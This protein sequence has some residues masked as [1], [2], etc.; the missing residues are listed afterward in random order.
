MVND[1]DQT[2]TLT[3][4]EFG[5]RHTRPTL[6]LDKRV[7]D[8]TTYK[9]YTI[10]AIGNGKHSIGF[11]KKQVKLTSNIERIND[12]AIIG[13]DCDLEFYMCDSP[14]LKYI[15]DN[16][17]YTIDTL[18]VHPGLTIGS[19][20]AVLDYLEFKDGTPVA[21]HSDKPMFQRIGFIN[22]LD[23]T[24]PT[25]NFPL[26]ASAKQFE[27]IITVPDNAKQAYL[28]NSYWKQ[29]RNLRTVSEHKKI[30]AEEAARRIEVTTADGY[31]TAKFRI[32]DDN[33]TVT[34]LNITSSKNSYPE[35][36]LSKPVI[37]PRT[38]KS[39]SITEIGD[40]EN[41]AGY[42]GA[43][44]ITPNIKRIN[45]YS[46]L[47]VKS[48]PEWNKV[49]YI[50]KYALH[51]E[52]V[53]EEIYI[54]PNTECVMNGSGYG[55][56]FRS[57]QFQYLRIGDGARLLA[58]GTAQFHVP[59]PIIRCDGTTPPELSAP[60][61]E[62]AA[63]YGSG[64]TILYVPREAIEA[65]RNH[66]EWG[67]IEDIYGFDR[68]L[69]L[70]EYD[71][72][73]PTEGESI[74]ITTTDGTYYL[75]VSPDEKYVTLSSFT[76]TTLST[77]PVEF[78]RPLTDPTTGK[79][80]VI[81]AISGAGVY[82]S[83]RIT[84]NIVR[85]NSGGLSSSS[86]IVIP[87]DNNLKY[88]G[89]NSFNGLTNI[90]DNIYLNDGAVMRSGNN[91][92]DNV[93]FKNVNTLGEDGGYFF[94]FSN[95]SAIPSGAQAPV[96]ECTTALPP[97]VFGTLYNS[98]ANSMYQNTTLI[99]P[100]GCSEIY[101]KA[102]EWFKIANIQESANS[103]IDQIPITDRQL[104]ILPAVGG[105]T[106]TTLEPVCVSIYNI[107]GKLHTVKNIPSGGT[108]ISIPAGLYVVKT[109]NGCA[110]KVMVK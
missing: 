7:M 79:S 17:A 15:G 33:T 52:Y 73:D 102:P 110:T 81:N 51:L 19:T 68:P 83:V 31:G 103:A 78:S 107:N 74:T 61:Y 14:N 95:E 21:I 72:Y 104:S 90:V 11:P 43:L 24:P 57:K 53:K 46:N 30:L 27:V 22:C 54:A 34:L 48:L 29:Y 99:V 98:Y 59:I 39:Y 36:N 100:K 86:T 9:V 108:V 16:S 12:N 10:T 87:E 75:I 76:P 32:N 8:P 66:A 105:I 97:V 26:S 13:N 25:V 91:F 2:V 60:L 80:Y 82:T 20:D 56:E 49:E 50:G 96:I 1:D 106:V 62:E 64:K 94:G 88:I 84:P 63:H 55:N 92:P 18:R 69:P 35:L 38:N 89:S 85:I 37:D 23:T 4:A 109:N 6:Y 65:Y 70:L 5:F 44:V 45:N 101:R 58:T 47:R 42:T 67:K 93:V 77:A 28:N 71:N 41:S 40:G 3:Y